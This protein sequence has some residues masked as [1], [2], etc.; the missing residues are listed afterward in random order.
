MKKVL[1]VA[2]VQSHIG[3]F[4]K[5][6]IDLLHQNGIE[7]HVAA[8]NNLIE[9][10]GLDIDCVDRVFDVPFSRS[11]LRYDNI[12]AYR[13]LKKIIKNGNY[14]VIHCNTPVGGVAARLAAKNE[15]KKGVKV[16]YTAH[17][18]HFYKGASLLNWLIYY[19]IEKICS[20]FTDT[21]ITINHEDYDLAKRKMRAKQVE[22][23][24]GVGVNVEK[25]KNTIV[26]RE[27]KRR[28]L[29]IPKE[30]IL[31]VSVGELNKNKNHQVIIK[32]VAQLNDANVHYMIAGNGPLQKDLLE[33]S[34]DL[35]ISEQVH[36]VG[37]RRDIAE[38]YKVSDVFCFPS[39]RE[40]LGLAAIEAMAAGLPV[41]AADN[42]GTREMVREK[43]NGYIC[44]N[45][46]AEGFAMKINYI[47]N[48]I[49]LRKRLSEAGQIMAGSFD[50]SV[51]MAQMKGI[52]Q[53]EKRV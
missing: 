24:P 10:N 6:L 34:A 12:R 5:P 33:L 21:L 45:N 47:I 7:V 48:D 3:Q 28:E 42:R 1:L 31:L 40:G 51:V 32:A 18:F 4:H 17:G 50:V 14:D 44:R 8:R 41:V 52:Y 15:R 38:L 27:V 13:Q 53:C 19:P 11:P 39:I 35:G 36:F 37:Y 26:D 49:D 9:K 16:L 29:G 46:D 25:F 43:T 22:Y 20:Y 23:I 2:T 30:A